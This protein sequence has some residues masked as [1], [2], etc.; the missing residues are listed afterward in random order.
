MK[1]IIKLVMAYSLLAFFSTL[2]ADVTEPECEAEQVPQGGAVGVRNPC[3]NE[4]VVEVPSEMEGE[5]NTLSSDDAKKDKKKKKKDKKD[6]KNK[7]KQDEK[8]RKD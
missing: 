1:R 8:D 5:G 7:E 2:Q 6:K 3:K 4:E